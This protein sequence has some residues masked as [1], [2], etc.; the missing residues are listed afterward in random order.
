MADRVKKV[1]AG[2][3]E[4][5]KTLTKDA[6]KSQ[7]YLYPLK[8]SLKEPRQGEISVDAIQ[9][10]LYFISHK[11]LWKPLASKLTPTLTLSFGVTTFM[12]V[13]AYLPQAAIMAFT[14]GP[15][16]AVTAALLTLSESS[17]IINILSRT[18]LI[19]YALIDTFDATLL[20]RD[21]TNLV[22]EGRHVTSAGDPMAR[23]GKLIKKPFSKFTPNAIIQHLLYLLLNLIPVVGTVIFIILQ[24]K[25]NGP[26]AHTRYFQLKQYSNSQIEVHVGQNRG[27]YTS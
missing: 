11:E 3:A 8:A 7:A 5:I 13:F 18:Y 1:A 14:S 20:S 19:E 10:I 24:G 15:V 12:F 2:E 26:A 4:R 6:A 16:A 22:S 17:T 23:L 27:A 25:N 9:G 21:C